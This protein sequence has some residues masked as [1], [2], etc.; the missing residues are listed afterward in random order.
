MRKRVLM[1]LLVVTLFCGAAWAQGI[2]NRDMSLSAGPSWTQSQT[3]GGT[4]VTLSGSKG[5]NAQSDFGYQVARAGAVSLMVD[6]SFLFSN[7]G[8]LFAN[9]PAVGRSDFS[10][11]TAG[12][13]FMVPVHPRLSFYVV[14]GG[15]YVSARSPVLTAGASPT[16]STHDTGH[17]VFAFGGGA[18]VRLSKWW[19]VR[20]EVRDFV[21][22]KDLA[23]VT[24]RHHVAPL[25]GV[26]LHF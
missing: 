5:W 19:S 2:Q 4:N 25:F 15:G 7:A 22:G 20:A 9:V 3:I 6:V 11:I 1:G 17:G 8:G 23:G 18:D 16:I 13:R 10:P 12:L 26:A 21:T 24:G 14:P